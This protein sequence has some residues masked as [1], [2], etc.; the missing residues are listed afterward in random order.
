MRILVRIFMT[1]RNVYVVQ[2]YEVGT[3][4][5]KSLAIII[6]SKLAKENHI[7][8]STIFT[9]KMSKNPVTM[10]L[11]TLND[12]IEQSKNISADKSLEASSQQMLSGAQ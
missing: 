11:Q 9:L 5:K 8:Q 1:T 10:T 4:N 12:I 2:P 3:K 7:S 6:P